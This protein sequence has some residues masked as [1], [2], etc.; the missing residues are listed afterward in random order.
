MHRISR[1]NVLLSQNPMHADWT[2][3]TFVSKGPYTTRQ[4]PE[5]RGPASGVELIRWA[6][7]LWHLDNYSSS[8]GFWGGFSETQKIDN[9]ETVSFS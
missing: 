8:I 6:I 5:D 4:A 9:L 1:S 2:D 7:S 3:A